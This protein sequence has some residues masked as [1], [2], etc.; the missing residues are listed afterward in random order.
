MNFNTTVGSPSRNG[1][2]QDGGQFSWII[3]KRLFCCIGVLPRIQTRQLPR[4][5]STGHFSD[6]RSNSCGAADGPTTPRAMT[7]K[8]RKRPSADCRL[9]NEKLRA[10]TTITKMF[11]AYVFQTLVVQQSET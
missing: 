8:G 6:R 5:R 9:E 10:V 2:R 1:T 7:G 3:A 4:R 11:I